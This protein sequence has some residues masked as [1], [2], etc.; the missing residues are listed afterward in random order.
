M[1]EKGESSVL[2]FK[3]SLRWDY[4][5]QQV[6]T[7]LQK[8]IAKTVAGFLNTEGGTLLI[9]VA[10]NGSIVGI[11]PDLKTLK[12]GSCDGFEL[13]LRNMLDASLGTEFSPYIHTS[14]AEQD[15]HTVCI[16]HIERSSQ[17]VYVSDKNTTEFYVR[18]G[19]ATRPLD[20]Q[21]TQSY[22]NMHWE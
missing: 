18:S 19:N 7:G 21:A 1:I 12:Q 5:E 15:G 9:G 8:V 22:I 2:E 17:P 20:V 13:T 16:V 11:E 3:S 4:R 6:N 14:F 10:D